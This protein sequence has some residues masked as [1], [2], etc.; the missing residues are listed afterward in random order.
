MTEPDFTPFVRDGRL[1]SLPA[2]QARREAVLRYLAEGS[3]APEHTYPESTVN[4]KLRAW[5][6]GGQVDHVAIRRY[7]IDLQILSRA[8]GVYWRCVADAPE[9]SRGERLIRG[10]GL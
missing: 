10:S 3:F 5:C 7:L 4:E 1:I 2:K 6:D 8:N 9:P